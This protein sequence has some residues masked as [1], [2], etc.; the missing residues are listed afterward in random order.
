MLENTP[1]CGS[2]VVVFSISM[3]EVVSSSRARA[4]RVKPKTFKIG[5]EYSLAKITAFKS[6]NHGSFG[7]DL[8]R[9]SRVAVDV[10]RKTVLTAKSRKC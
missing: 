7:Y 5:S 1:C 2:L 4:G 3:R 10:A 8:K 9:K 6:E